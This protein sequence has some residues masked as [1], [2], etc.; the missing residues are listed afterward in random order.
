ML[1]PSKHQ[2]EQQEASIQTNMFLVPSTFLRLTSV[3]ECFSPEASVPEKQE[4]F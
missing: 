3:E 1:C 2:D 4:H